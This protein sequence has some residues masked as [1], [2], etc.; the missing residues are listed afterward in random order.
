MQSKPFKEKK[1]N[2]THYD[3]WKNFWKSNNQRI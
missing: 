1:N 2:F 3:A